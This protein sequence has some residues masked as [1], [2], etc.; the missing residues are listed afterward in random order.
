MHISSL[1]IRNFRNFENCVFKFN[2][3]VNTIIGENGSGKTNAFYALRILLDSKLPRYANNLSESDFNRSLESWKGHW[4]VISLNFEELTADEAIQCLSFLEAGIP[5]GTNRGNYNYFFRPKH[6]IR[7]EL[8]DLSDGE[9]RDEDALKE[10][11]ENLTIADYEYVITVGASSMDFSNDEFYK[12][13]VGD[14]DELIFPNPE[15]AQLRFVP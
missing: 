1:T 5:D 8:F 11:L 6:H 9:E 3:G 13:H 10:K 4:I 12:E 7:K 2:K 14:F 15:G